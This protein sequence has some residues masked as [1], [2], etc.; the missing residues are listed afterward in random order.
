MCETDALLL[1]DDG[2]SHCGGEVV[3]HDNG[4][5]L[6]VLQIAFEGGHHLSRKLVKVLAVDTKEDVGT[7]HLKVVEE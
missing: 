6:V 2:S 4:V 7:T 3:H 5:G 1:C